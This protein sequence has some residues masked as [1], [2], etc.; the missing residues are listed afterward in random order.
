MP[1]LWMVNLFR[2]AVEQPHDL[3]A[4]FRSKASSDSTKVF[5]ESSGSR[6]GNRSQ[7]SKAWERLTSRDDEGKGVNDGLRLP[8]Y[9]RNDSGG[10][11]PHRVALRNKVG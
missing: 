7:P 2:T 10:R 1:K 8:R 5:S 11:L 6:V 9:A 4:D 3:T